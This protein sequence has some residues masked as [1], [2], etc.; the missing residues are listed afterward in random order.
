MEM[1]D[2]YDDMHFKE[3]RE[4]P[5]YDTVVYLMSILYMFLL[6]FL[7]SRSRRRRAIQ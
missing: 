6:T 7:F 3:Y 1:D 4:I 2:E 5:L